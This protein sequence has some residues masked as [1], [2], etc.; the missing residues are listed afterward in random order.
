MW[1]KN[2]LCLS[3]IILVSLKTLWCTLLNNVACPKLSQQ[4]CLS[5]R[6]Y[7][8]IFLVFWVL[9][10]LSLKS[11]LCEGWEVCCVSK[12][13]SCWQVEEQV[14]LFGLCLDKIEEKR[15]QNQS[16]TMFDQVTN[17][18]KRLLGHFEP[19]YASH[20]VWTKLQHWRVLVFFS[21]CHILLFWWDKEE[22]KRD[23]LHSKG[24]IVEGLYS[25]SSYGAGL[26][27]W[28]SF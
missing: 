22:W 10:S 27:T 1:L 4:T 12:I 7:E 6:A 13:W 19:P 2:K 9:I 15:V 18:Y 25:R 8:I 3:F 17:Y 28:W 16:L 21:H 5:L 14:L 11:S 26:L 24:F 23:S 20:I